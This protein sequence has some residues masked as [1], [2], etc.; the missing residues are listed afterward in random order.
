[1]PPGK[2]AL[3]KLTKET[4]EDLKENRDWWKSG[5]HVRL[6][7]HFCSLGEWPATVKQ[8]WL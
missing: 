6:H 2:Q 7:T 1:M 5:K 8:S 3:K 4:E